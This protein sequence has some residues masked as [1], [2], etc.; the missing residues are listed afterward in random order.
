MAVS[1]SARVPAHVVIAG[2][3]FAALET[4][5]ACRALLPKQLRLTLVS[6]EPLFAYRPA[7]TAEAFDESHSLA[8][9]LQAIADDLE[10][11]YHAVRLE[12]VASR[13]RYVRVSSGIR[14]NYDALVL[15]L[16]ARARASLPGAITFRDQRDVPRFRRLLDELETGAARRVAFVVPTG[17]SWPLPIY[18]LAMLSA[19]RVAQH[20][21]ATEIL[22]ISPEQRPLGIFGADASSLVAGLLAERGVRLIGDAAAGIQRGGALL[23]QSGSVV[24][25]ERVVAAPQ[26]RG[27]YITG[28]PANR[29]GF[30]PTDAFGQVDGVAGIYA[31]GDMT[32][33]P[34]KHGGLATQHA[35]RIAHA[36][37]AEHGAPVR[38]LRAARVLQVRLVGGRSPV[39]LRTELDEFGVPTGASLEHPAPDE[40]LGFAK[41][42]GR[43]LTP[44]LETRE[45]LGLTPRERVAA[46]PP[47]SRQVEHMLSAPPADPDRDPPRERHQE[48][49][50]DEHGERDQ[51][52]SRGD[53]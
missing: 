5:L 11:A 3:G 35:D 52:D 27:P 4:A 46:D 43:Y 50:R 31:A 38:E 2:G 8:Y 25:V 41:V 15:A 19:T 26:L 13:D 37:A 42:F 29:W 45:P 39:L 22:L 7:A 18:E 36:I 33:F 1:S 34:I 32:T 49:E 21:L 6:A 16:G 47:G 51:H 53:G 10:I 23:L 9:D 17:C 28:V 24:E 44:Y 12:S 48:S 30:V 20:G 40:M 14:L